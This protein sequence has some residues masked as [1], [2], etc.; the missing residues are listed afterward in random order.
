MK[1]VLLA[2]LGVGAVAVLVQVTMLRELLVVFYGNELSFGMIM[3]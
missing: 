2:M 3:G 1:R